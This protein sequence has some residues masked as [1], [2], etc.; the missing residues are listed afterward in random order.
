MRLALENC[1]TDSLTFFGLRDCKVDDESFAGM[2]GALMVH[3]RLNILDLDDTALDINT[4]KKLALFLRWSFT[5]LSYLYLNNTTIDDQGLDLDVLIIALAGKSKLQ[6]VDLSRNSA[7]TP[8]GLRAFST[9][10]KSPNCNLE[11]LN[12]YSSNVHVESIIAFASALA[13]N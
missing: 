8:I 3:S 4:Y 5:E 9:L 2:L 1:A 10:L 7:I 11:T 12:I 6:T 13:N